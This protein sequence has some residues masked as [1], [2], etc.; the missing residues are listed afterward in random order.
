MTRTYLHSSLGRGILLAETAGL[1]VIRFESG[2]QTC[3]PA[4][5]TLLQSAAEPERWSPPLAALT[6]ALALA[7]RSANDRWGVFTASRI[8]LLPH[9]LWVCKR[10]LEDEPARWL[11]AD[12][13]GLG[14]TVEA[15]LIISAL[16]GAG[17]LGRLLIL[18]PAGL[19]Q[20]WQNRLRSQFD[21]A[22]TIYD[23]ASDTADSGF[24]EQHDCV[25]GSIQTLR[26]DRKGRHERLLAHPWDLII[27]D[28][29]HHVHADV[30]GAT[31]AY[32]FVEKIVR[33][34]RTRS[35][36]FFTGT[37]HRGKDHDFFALLQLLRPDLFDP[38]R[39]FAPQLA[40]LGEVMIR[41]NKATVTDMQG[42]RIFVPTKVRTLDWHHSPEEAAFYARLTD[43][44]LAGRAFASGLPGQQQRTAFLVLIALQKLASSSV[45]AV[46]GALAK[47][48]ARALKAQ[49]VMSG[50]IEE[51]TRLSAL[52]A[53]SPE[54]EDDRRR[55]EEELAGDYLLG[56]EEIPHL[57]TLLGQA[58]AIGSESRIEAI[59]ALVGDDRDGPSI[60]FFTEYKATQAL[61][62]A[63]LAA[64]FGRDAVTFINGD[65]WLDLPGADGTVRRVNSERPAAA[66][67]FNVGKTRFLV[68]TEAAGEGIDLH[69]RCHTLVHVDVPWNPMRMHQRVGRLNRFGQT[70]TVEVVTLRNEETVEGRIFALLHKKLERINEALRGAMD[71]P[72]D[73]MQL[74]LGRQSMSFFENLFAS[75]PPSGES[76]NSWFDAKT[77][78]FGSEDAVT[79]VKALI[80]SVSRFDFGSSM[81]GLPR[82][83]LPDLL[84][85]MRATLALHHSRADEQ[86]RKLEFITPD[87]WRGTWG[88]LRAYRDGHSLL[89][90][91]AVARKQPGILAGVGLTLVDTALSQALQQ[92]VVA[93][94]IRGLSG[95][96]VV[97]SIDDLETASRVAP[98]SAI[99]A[100]EQ[101]TDG[102][103]LLREEALIR[104][105]NDL[106]AH[107]RAAAMTTSPPPPTEPVAALVEE[108]ERYVTSE[109][110][111]LELS[112]RRP[113]VLSRMV[114]C[115]A[116]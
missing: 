115:P 22:T 68:S 106:V 64:R 4:S 33:N 35:L 38:E 21:L 40:S 80:G 34:A 63:A 48:L 85:F 23:A 57:Q 90:D 87:A 79:V 105:L 11:I 114:L 108:A 13:V 24:W 36:L 70:E 67:L 18:C 20:Q 26:D 73:M 77:A 17:R 14:K 82:L 45:A 103:T 28:E 98:V 111:K 59:M 58:A 91:R 112:F 95:A 74:V 49:A 61:V 62:V 96:I 99:V 94:V 72:E 107:P 53:P 50:R 89:F 41:N 46:R 7:I 102:W 55:V 27:V 65:G 30:D 92:D 88:I 32:R 19:T 54:E 8:E 2:I 60:L 81:N 37:P 76:L 97:C 116:R 5:V 25:I 101:T 42:R 29:A 78:S 16:R 10:V 86:E 6:R 52:D 43:Y 1:L 56:T 113:Q 9:Q 71:E 100:A 66:A 47:R 44:I 39:P 110:P 15:G 31:K 93:T 69:H 84:P 12:D 109:L 3:E 104:R 51:L 75:A 83:D